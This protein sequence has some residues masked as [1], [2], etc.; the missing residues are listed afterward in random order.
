MAQGNPNVVESKSKAVLVGQCNCI[1]K[2]HG[3]PN[4]SVGTKRMIQTPG[5]KYVLCLRYIDNY[6]FKTV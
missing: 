3:L 6:I 5:M 2:G 4:R 1:Y